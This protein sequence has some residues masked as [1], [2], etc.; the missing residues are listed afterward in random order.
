MGTL[1]E[2]LRFAEKALKKEYID[3]LDGWQTLDVDYEPPRVE[4]LWRNLGGIYQDHRLYL[5][6]IHPC[7]KALFHP[8]PWPSAVK[9]LSGT[10][11]MGIG[12]ME[13]GLMP[14]GQHPTPP[15][16]AAKILLTAGSSYEMVNRS[17]WHWVRPLGGPSLSLM[18][19]A[20]KWDI[21]WSPKPKADHVLGPLTDE[22]KRDLLSVFGEFY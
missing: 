14:A 16:V 13:T 19:T 8:H 3:D 1:L 21:Q 6:R 7:E 17:G 15:P 9:I 11:E 22:A 10:Y 5:H 4:R 20:P 18:V 2:V 12:Y